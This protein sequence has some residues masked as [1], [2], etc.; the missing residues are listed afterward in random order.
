VTRRLTAGD[1]REVQALLDRLTTDDPAKRAFLREKLL[2][3]PEV[4]PTFVAQAKRLLG[5]Q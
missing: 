2:D 3:R 4:W 5:E 1:W